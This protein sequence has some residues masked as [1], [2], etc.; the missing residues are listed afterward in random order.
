MGLTKLR[1]SEK[2]REPYL[3]QSARYYEKRD[4]GEKPKSL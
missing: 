4:F 1:E 2:T 3:S